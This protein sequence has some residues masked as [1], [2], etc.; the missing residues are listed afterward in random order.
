MSNGGYGQLTPDEIAARCERLGAEVDQRGGR[1]WVFPPNGTSRPIVFSVLIMKGNH[2]RNVVSDLRKAGLD[3]MTDRAR[4]VAPK[5]VNP[6]PVVEPQQSGE[7]MATPTPDQMPPRIAAF[8]A[9]AAVAD[10]RDQL[11]Q[12]SDTTIKMLAEA[13]DRVTAAEA[14]IGELEGRVEVFAPAPK[15]RPPSAGELIQAAILTFFREQLPRNFK[16]SP[17]SVE[18]NIAEWLPEKRAKTAVAHACRELAIAG[19]LSGGA[20]S[21]N[22][23]HGLY[24]LDPE[25]T[26]D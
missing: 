15:V 10:L 12:L 13:E 22:P 5:P 17:S 9:R 14:R 21:A 16:V 26:T 6:A 25:P 1:W 3:V 2:A 11:R 23:I 19:K 7:P 18:G 24:W 20:G 4:G 8:D